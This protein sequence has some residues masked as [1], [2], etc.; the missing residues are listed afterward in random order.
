MYSIRASRVEV[1]IM[2]RAESRRV[3]DTVTLFLIDG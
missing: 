3:P 2:E 1:E